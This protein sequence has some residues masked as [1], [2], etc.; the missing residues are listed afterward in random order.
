[1]PLYNFANSVHPS[2]RFGKEGIR[3]FLV[4]LKE[5]LEKA[6]TRHFNGAYSLLTIMV[7]IEA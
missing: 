2:L 1:M 4:Y 3:E 6:L 7:M 5:L